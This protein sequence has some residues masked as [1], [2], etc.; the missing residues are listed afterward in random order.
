MALENCVKYDKCDFCN[1]EDASEKKLQYQVINI[2]SQ[3]C[4]NTRISIFTTHIQRMRRVMFLQLS[5]QTGRGYPQSC[6]WSCP[7]S[8]LGWGGGGWGCPLVPGR[9]E[10]LGPVQSRSKVVPPTRQGIT[11]PPPRPQ[12]GYSTALLLKHFPY[13]TTKYVLI[14]QMCKVSLFTNK[15]TFHTNVRAIICPTRWKIDNSIAHGSPNILP[16]FQ[17]V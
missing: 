14:P 11:P 10:P 7:K 6:H 15:K 5:V 4:S 12:T 8:G 13:F 17:T 3:L 1:N 9:W 2:T 16:T